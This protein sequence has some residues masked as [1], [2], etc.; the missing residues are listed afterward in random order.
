MNSIKVT[1]KAAK[2]RASVTD[3]K[4]DFLFIMVILH[5]LIKNSESGRH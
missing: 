3:H 2:T 1:K 4:M 5:L